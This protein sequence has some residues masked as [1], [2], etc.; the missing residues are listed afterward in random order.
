[1][2]IN[3][4]RSEQPNINRGIKIASTLSWSWGVLAFLGAIALGIPIVAQGGP[5]AFP[6][7]L[8]VFSI[9]FC[10][11]GFGIRKQRRYGMWISITKFY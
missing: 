7:L 4:L 6:S 10:V 2:N 1:M 9:L 8:L 3:E 5:I 11:S